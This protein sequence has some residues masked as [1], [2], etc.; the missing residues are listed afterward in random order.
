MFWWGNQT[1]NERTQ[2]ILDMF[3][4]ANP[5]VTI[6]GQFADGTDY[7]TRL[8]TLSAGGVIPDVIQMEYEFISQYHDNGSLLDLTPY[9]DSGVIDLS[10]VSETIIIPGQFGDKYFGVA[11][12]INAFSLLYNKTLLDEAGIKVNDNMTLEE[13][14]DIC[15]E[16]YEKTGY[17]TDLSY[18]AA[19]S[20]SF[21]EYL[22]RA[23]DIQ[24][25]GDGAFGVNSA[26]DFEE[27]FTLFEI[28]IQEGWHVDPSVY[29][30]RQLAAVEQ[31][32]L[33]YGSNPANR[34]WC[35]FHASNQITA[36]Q[37]AAHDGVEI[38]LTV[39]PSTNVAVSNFLRP[40]QFFC[41]SAD[42][43]Y[44]DTAAAL[45]NFITN[46]VECNE[47]L[48]AERGIPVSAVVAE[49]ILP[50]LSVENQKA[51]AYIT[52]VVTPNSTA[53]NPPPSSAAA[54]IRDLIAS[55]LERLLY[56]EITAQEAAAQF[57]EQ[58]NAIMAENAE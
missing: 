31:S 21:L 58:G 37:A 18:G 3:M 56:Q 29:A 49:A 48:L 28:G 23:H 2:Q 27:F 54:E 32:C 46:S 6:D 11:N 43:Q 7:W 15:R 55:I 38:A 9:V 4:E 34:S 26:E 5:G 50:K 25:F 39:L 24:L 20:T 41:I 51:T 33:V 30:E 13:F 1:R 14:K 40:A 10:N 8:A 52:D 35:G 17:K 53:I 16:V 44:P 42:S 45:I 19:T 57:Y 36:M 12:G 47:V 22:L